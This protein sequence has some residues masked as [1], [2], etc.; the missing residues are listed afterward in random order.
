MVADDEGGNKK[1]DRSKLRPLDLVIDDYSDVDN[2]DERQSPPRGYQ[3]GN[4]GFLE[5]Y[6]FIN[7]QYG[8]DDDDGDD[9]KPIK[10]RRWVGSLTKP[11]VGLDSPT[12]IGIAG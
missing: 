10:K 8:D 11:A 12:L 9:D 3:K 7:Y 6:D 4:G 1:F 2:D 5:P